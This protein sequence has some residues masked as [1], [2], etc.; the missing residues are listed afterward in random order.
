MLLLA[1]RNVYYYMYNKSCCTL[2]IEKE[3]K[4][5]EEAMVV[6]ELRA[7]VAFYYSRGY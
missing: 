2:F 5:A 1:M 4:K 7:F 3:R 6:C